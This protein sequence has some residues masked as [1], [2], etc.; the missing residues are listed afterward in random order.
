MSVSAQL[1]Y[2]KRLNALRSTFYQ[3]LAGNSCGVQVA[4][5]EAQ[6]RHARR[7]PLPRQ[8]LPLSPLTST[9]TSF[10]TCC[11][12]DSPRAFSNSSKMTVRA[13]KFTP[14]VLLSAPRRSAAT[15]NAD[16]TLAV[17]TV[18][19]YSFDTH[20]K[21]SEIRVLDIK[22]GSSKVLSSDKGTSEPTW[23]EK[24]LLLWL[25]GGE[26]GTTNLI[27]ADATNP[28]DKYC[29][30]SFSNWHVLMLPGLKRL[31]LSMAVSQ[32]SK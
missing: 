14:E 1:P 22:T 25:K 26:K 2:C 19:T 16:G 30:A 8:L 29:I 11:S 15:P 18:S 3:G 32:T 27:L 4:T 23:L 5:F 7:G 24:D 6:A 21:S 31:P 20:S 12:P 13:N 9:V 10:L 17:Y 28:K